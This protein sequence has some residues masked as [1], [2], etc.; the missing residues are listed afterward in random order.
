MMYFYL[1]NRPFDIYHGDYQVLKAWFAFFQEEGYHPVQIT[2]DK[3]E[4]LMAQG[5][6]EHTQEVWVMRRKTQPPSP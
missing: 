2:L 3:A 5:P 4:A 1:A 6:D